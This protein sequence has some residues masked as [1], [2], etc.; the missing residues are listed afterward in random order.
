MVGAS[1]ADGADSVGLVAGTC[2]ALDVFPK[3]HAIM[4]D[5][6]MQVAIKGGIA[7]GFISL[8]LGMA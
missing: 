8:F 7:W 5:A 2:V 3:L 4:A 6:N 1:V